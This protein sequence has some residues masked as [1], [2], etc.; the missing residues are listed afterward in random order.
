MPAS[1]FQSTPSSW[2]T[3]H[4]NTADLYD[5][6]L[7]TAFYFFTSDTTTNATNL[8]GLSTSNSSVRKFFRKVKKG[9][10]DIKQLFA[11]TTMERML[12]HHVYEYEKL[13]N[14]RLKACSLHYNTHLEQSTTILD[15][16]GKTQQHLIKHEK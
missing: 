1:T 13:V 5:S 6:S 7:I 11:V 12:Q 3:I 2:S 15:M 8:E 10:L 14:Y 16:K 4:G 9:L